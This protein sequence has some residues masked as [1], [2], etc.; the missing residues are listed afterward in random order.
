VINSKKIT[1]KMK[2]T[3]YSLSMF[4]ASEFKEIR[5]LSQSEFEKYSDY[6]VKLIL[7]KNDENLFKI[8]EL[9]YA[10]FISKIEHITNQL[11]ENDLITEDQQ[12]LHLE[13]N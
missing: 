5:S 3:A 8:V 11:I 10:D 13:V 1:I 7:L 4:K 2:K 9:N 6:I 12:Y